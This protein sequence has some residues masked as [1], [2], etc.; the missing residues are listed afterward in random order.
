[1]PPEEKASCSTVE[2]AA[3]I[4]RLK[5][6]ITNLGNGVDEAR[7]ERVLKDGGIEYVRAKKF[8]DA[9]SGSLWF[10]DEAQKNKAKEALPAV[11]AALGSNVQVLEC[12]EVNRHRVE[13]LSKRHKGSAR[14][15]PRSEEHEGPVDVNDVV[16][17]LHTLPYERQLEKKAADVRKTVANIVERLVKL[18][19]PLP[20]RHVELA[21]G[22]AVVP[23]P[24]TRGFRNKLAFSISTDAAGARC[25]GFSEGNY[26]DG[27]MHVVSAKGCVLVSERMEAVREAVEALVQRSALSVYDKQ[28]H[29]G[30]Y[31][32]LELREF[33]TGDTLAVLQVNSTGVAADAL[34]AE[35]TAFTRLMRDELHVTAAFVQY[36]SGVSNFSEAP[37][38]LLYGQPFATERVLGLAF[39]VAPGSFFQTNTR[40]METLYSTVRQFCND[41]LADSP[42]PAATTSAVTTE[43][44]AAA[45]KRRVVLFDVCCG[46]GTI[47]QILAKECFGDDVEVDIYGVD[48]CAEAIS[49]AQ[50]N[51]ERNRAA[52]THNG[53][54]VCRASYVA[55]KAEEHMEAMV[56]SAAPQPRTTTVLAVVDPPRGGLHPKV[57]RALRACRALEHLVYVS[58]S[59]ASLTN[60]AV[61]LCRP[62]S[63]TTFGMPFHPVKAV[64][65]D[66]FPQT[67][68]LE[69]VM[70]FTRRN[71]VE[72]KLK[73]AASSAVST[74]SP[75]TAT[76]TEPTTTTP[77][78]ATETSDS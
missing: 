57:I 71:I 3:A 55:G 1:M 60:D 78:Q 74:S 11:L 17:P 48:T 72:N 14:K 75:T 50:R 2:E 66:M 47:G 69:M 6:I 37:A 30:F 20:T 39:T 68:H 34:Q 27:H 53:A 59:P 22:G 13:S 41:L 15:R 32:Q 77:T 21:N 19:C 26:S 38:Q 29:K 24:V 36:H 67:K 63:K 25:V 16:A 8:F 35:L 4:V 54:R 65:V 40:G 9:N 31:R 10:A 58:C 5:L 18:G 49:D 62:A 73:E 64:G 56:R 33:T 12:E 70:L 44:P 42:A 23:S 61:V 76:G 43:A 7:F 46:T 51:F 52:I 28:T 45:A